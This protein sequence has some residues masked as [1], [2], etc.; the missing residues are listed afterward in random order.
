MDSLN[1]VKKITNKI[2]SFPLCEEN[3]NTFKTSVLKRKFV[4]HLPL[5]A[6]TLF[7]GSSLKMN[8]VALN[9]NGFVGLRWT[10]VL[11]GTATYA[12][13]RNYFGQAQAFPFYH[14]HGF[15]W[16]MLRTGAAVGTVNGNNAT[17]LHETSYPN[18]DDLFLFGRLFGNGAGGANLSTFYAIEVAKAFV[19]I[20]FG[21][22]EP[23]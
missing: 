21:L 19:I 23:V 3:V 15:G 14:M 7:D 16:A 1:I 10:G 4:E 22:H 18:L 17:L 11:A 2:S 13:I 6:F 8:K 12:Q 5:R 9:I 20:K